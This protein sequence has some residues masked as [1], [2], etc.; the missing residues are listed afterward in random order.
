MY[1]GV[2]IHVC[3]LHTVPGKSTAELVSTAELR[4]FRSK[5]NTNTNTNK[6]HNPSNHRQIARHRSNLT[7]GHNLLGALGGAAFLE[8]VDRL[9]CH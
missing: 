2:N 8:D 4:V 3:V 9:N 5:R 7:L 6:Q 1:V